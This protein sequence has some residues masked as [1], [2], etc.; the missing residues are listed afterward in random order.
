MSFPGDI[1]GKE[2]SCNAGE[3][4]S[5]S[6]SGRSPVEGNGNPLQYTGLGNPIDRGAWG[7]TVMGHKDSDMTEQLSL[8]HNKK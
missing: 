6:G 8:T 4:G 3:L 7:A 1:D 2:F 5:I